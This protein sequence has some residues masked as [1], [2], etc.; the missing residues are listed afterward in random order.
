MNQA[1]KH[2]NDLYNTKHM[3]SNEKKHPDSIRLRNKIIINHNNLLLETK[4]TL[5]I[6]SQFLEMARPLKFQ[7]LLT[8]TIPLTV[9]TNC[10]RKIL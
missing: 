4:N 8:L 9:K 10:N 5:L 2:N 3:I 6:K 1:L 7:L